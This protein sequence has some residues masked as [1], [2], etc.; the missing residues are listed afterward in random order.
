MIST[1]HGNLI[2]GQPVAEAKAK[3]KWERNGCETPGNN[4]ACST[5]LH[6]ETSMG[7][8]VM[9]GGK[10][11]AVVV[12]SVAPRSAGRLSG[13]GR[14]SPGVRLARLHSASSRST[15]RRKE[16]IRFQERRENGHTVGEGSRRRVA[17]S[18]TAIPSQAVCGAARQ[19]GLL[20]RYW[21]KA[22]LITDRVGAAPLCASSFSR[23]DAARVRPIDPS[24]DQISARK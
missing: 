15:S 4:S 20:R 12:R 22:S 10:N 21:C 9:H 17:F 7:S 8:R 18:R 23:G 13:T 14:R 16:R 6:L 11:G 19:D 24:P 5:S 3:D 2:A 1:Q